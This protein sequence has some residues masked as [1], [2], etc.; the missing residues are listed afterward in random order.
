MGLAKSLNYTIGNEE[1]LMNLVQAMTRL[2]LYLR[3][4]LLIQGKMER[5]RNELR[6]SLSLLTEFLS[7]FHFYLYLLF[8]FV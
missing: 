1:P 2:D 4:F 6:S 8:I 7:D 3:K 5:L